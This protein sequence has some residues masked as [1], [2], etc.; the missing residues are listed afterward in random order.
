MKQ[1]IEMTEE[2]LSE[3]AQMRTELI[4]LFN[5]KNQ[6]SFELVRKLDTLIEELIS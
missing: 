6:I 2:Q 5:S 1:T 3:L 4:E